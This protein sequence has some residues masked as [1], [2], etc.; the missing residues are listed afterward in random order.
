M[1]WKGWRSR[2]GDY[3][4]FDDSQVVFTIF[5]DDSRFAG[6]METFNS[7]IIEQCRKV[8]E[9]VRKLA[10]PHAEYASM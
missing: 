3:W 4:L 6:G 1:G 8:Y 9:Q 5:E 2:G 10:V 7:E